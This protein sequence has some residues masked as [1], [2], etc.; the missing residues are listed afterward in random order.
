MPGTR[1]AEPTV[2]AGACQVA[3]FGCTANFIYYKGPEAV[4]PATSDGRQHFIGTAGHRGFLPFF[5]GNAIGESR[6]D[7]DARHG[8]R[9]F[10]AVENGGP[11]RSG[12]GTRAGSSAPEDGGG[13]LFY[14]GDQVI[15]VVGTGASARS[16]V[17]APG[18]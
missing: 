12:R 7:S 9:I 14:A 15:D 4:V 8:H 10:G 3:P 2:K 11:P 16:R 18:V 13:V 1:S 5:G 6:Y 17:F